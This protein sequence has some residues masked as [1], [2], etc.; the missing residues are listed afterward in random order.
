METRKVRTLRQ[1]DAELS[2]NLTMC[3]SDFERSN[4]RAIGG[5]EIRLE[6]ER[7]ATERPLTSVEIGIASK[8]GYRAP[9]EREVVNANSE[10]NALLDTS[11]VKLIDAAIIAVDLH[12]Q[13]KGSGLRLVAEWDDSDVV[14]SGL[15]Y[16]ALSTVG[17]ETSEANE[18]ELEA[19]VSPILFGAYY[20]FTEDRDSRLAHAVAAIERSGRRV[21]EIRW[22]CVANHSVCP[23]TEEEIVPGF[24]YWPFVDKHPVS[25]SA[26]N[27]DAQEMM[28]KI[29]SSVN[30]CSAS[31]DVQQIAGYFVTALDL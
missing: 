29:M 25:M 21:A 14:D 30:W 9:E 3:H 22:N 8:Y 18:A 28:S 24:G 4:C 13:E 2:Q 27:H 7:I 23:L 16:E 26:F 1:L 19:I 15:L 5:K 6:A 20:Q 31:E 10:G 17:I 11:T 12:R